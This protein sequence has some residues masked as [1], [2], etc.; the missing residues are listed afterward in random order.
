[1]ASFHVLVGD[2]RTTVGR[3]NLYRNQRPQRLLH[4]QVRVFQTTFVAYICTE[5]PGFRII[6]TKLHEEITP[7][8]IEECSDLS[9]L[10]RALH[11][12]TA[13]SIAAP[14]S[15]LTNLMTQ[16]ATA[17]SVN[18]NGNLAQAGLLPTTPMSAPPMIGALNSHP[19]AR[20]SLERHQ[21]Q[22]QN[23]HHHHHHQQH[24][25]PSQMLAQ[26]G[27]GSNGNLNG[28]ASSSALGHLE[29][30]PG[31]PMHNGF[32]LSFNGP[33]ETLSLFDQLNGT[34]FTF[35]YIQ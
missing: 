35:P 9:Q 3:W 14:T 23:Q 6:R 1:M 8:D 30:A 29:M 27:M 24:H 15:A 19:L 11:D 7:E 16:S 21:Q 4:K 10:E 26:N 13:A 28:S 31:S 12:G 18:S 20:H 2:P 25:M 34:A 5:R 17:E 32:S 33:A 22:H